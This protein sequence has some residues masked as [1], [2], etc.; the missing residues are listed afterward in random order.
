MFVRSY[1]V[2]Y[3]RYIPGKQGFCFHYHCTDYDEGKYSDTFWLADH[4]RLFVH[5]TISLSSLWK[6][7]WRHWTYEMPVRYMLSSVWVRLIIFSQLSIIQYMGLCVFSLPFSFVMI[8]II[9][10]LS[11]YR[12][13][14]GSMNYYSLFRVMSWNNG[15]R[16]MSL[17][18]L[19]WILLLPVSLICIK[20]CK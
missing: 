7:I 15:M 5:Y 16:C 20:M 12:H 17:S 18:L 10:T 2:S 11:Y 19:L 6:F 8:E 4:V 14:I 3:W 13:Q 9:Y 1:S